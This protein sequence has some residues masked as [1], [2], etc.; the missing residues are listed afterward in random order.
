M[1]IIHYQIPFNTMID[2][3]SISLQNIII[4]FNRYNH[5]YW[6]HLHI[7]L[8]LP[9]TYLSIYSHQSNNRYVYSPIGPLL[10][11][12]EFDQLAIMLS[13]NK[14]GSVL[15]GHSMPSTTLLECKRKPR[16]SQLLTYPPTDVPTS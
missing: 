4:I 10:P 11:L 6:D 7:L 9:I 14:R 2:T 15:P 12:V 1:I 8:T 13:S 3:R 5:K 16:I